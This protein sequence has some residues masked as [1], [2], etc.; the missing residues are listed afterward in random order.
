MSNDR[1]TQALLALVALALLANA[2]NPWLEPRPVS[3]AQAPDTLSRIEETVA[4]INENLEVIA[5]G[6]CMNGN[7][8]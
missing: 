5:L 1:I 3:A 7:L 6:S 4:N 2:V 8:C